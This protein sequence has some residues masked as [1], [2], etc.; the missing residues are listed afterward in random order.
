[1]STGP[2]LCWLGSRSSASMSAM[3]FV[4]WVTDPVTTS[5]VFATVT[6]GV[7]VMVTEPLID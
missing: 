4:P 7:F 2:N 6:F 5:G 3:T 1:M